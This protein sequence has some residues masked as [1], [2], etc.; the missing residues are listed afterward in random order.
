MTIRERLV[1]WMFRR[2]PE[3]WTMED[4]EWLLRRLEKL[5]DLHMKWQMIECRPCRYLTLGLGWRQL[6]IPPTGK[7][8]LYEFWW[9]WL[10]EDVEDLVRRG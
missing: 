6:G 8:P 10:V 2:I 1:A 9:E 3:D 7:P 5:N 4:A